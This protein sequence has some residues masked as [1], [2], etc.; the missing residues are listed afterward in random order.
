MTKV[1]AD[2]LNSLEL[3]SDTELMMLAARILNS[4]SITGWTV[5]EFLAYISEE[6]AIALADHLDELLAPWES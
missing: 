4:V 1:V 3:L 5:A 6:Q 2:T